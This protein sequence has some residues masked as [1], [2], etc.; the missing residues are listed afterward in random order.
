MT[1]PDPSPTSAERQPIR[2]W[3]V[4]CPFNKKGFPVVGSF[5]KTIRNV[6]IIPTDTW[7]RLCR[8]HPTLAA[9][10]FEVGHYTEDDHE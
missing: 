8:E 9:T 4:A 1:P 2:I 10:Q 3:S 5:G 6:V 7:T